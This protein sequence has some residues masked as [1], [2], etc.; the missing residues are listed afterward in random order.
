MSDERRRQE[1]G[2]ILTMHGDIKTVMADQ[3]NMRQDIKD[4]CAT[5][6]TT[7]DRGRENEQKITGIMAIGS[8]ITFAWTSA[9]A[10]L[11]MKK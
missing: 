8:L 6:K 11:G 7:D 10:Y 4:V 2:L 9:I 3:K 5:L 1:D